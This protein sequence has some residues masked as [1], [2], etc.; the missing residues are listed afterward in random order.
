MMAARGTKALVLAA[1]DP[2]RVGHVLESTIAAIA[3]AS[4]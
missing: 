3:L 2:R 1:A 4:L